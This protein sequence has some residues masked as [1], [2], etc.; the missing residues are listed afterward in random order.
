MTNL[1]NESSDPESLDLS[2]LRILV[3]E[4]SWQLGIAMSSLTRLLQ[5]SASV[6][7]QPS[8]PPPAKIGPGK[9]APAMGPGDGLPGSQASVPI[10]D[11]AA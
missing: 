10:H 5:A 9:A 8:R 3:V 11:D 7:T 6:A 1:S 2:G 4:D